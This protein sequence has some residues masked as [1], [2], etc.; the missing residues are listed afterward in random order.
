MPAFSR[1]KNIRK[2][3]DTLFL[4]IV[5]HVH[6][7]ITAG[8]LRS[9]KSFALFKVQLSAVV[10]VFVVCLV[11]AR[12]RN[13]FTG[14]EFFHNCP[15]E[16]IMRRKSTF[17]QKFCAH[18][19]RLKS[20]YCVLWLIW[21]QRD[22]LCHYLDHRTNRKGIPLGNKHYNGIFKSYYGAFTFNRFQPSL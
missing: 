1:Q 3:A 7:I 13:N 4:V 12:H 21:V 11:I 9:G 16:S 8:M 19:A 10:S 18:S 14:S 17:I 20:V 2:I 15:P 5:V 22:V 6:Y